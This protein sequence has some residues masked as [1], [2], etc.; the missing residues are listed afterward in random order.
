MTAT[1]VA[2]STRA[3]R[4]KCLNEHFRSLL[5]EPRPVGLNPEVVGL[6]A[7]APVPFGALAHDAAGS[8]MT[9]V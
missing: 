8:R 3:Y 2:S 6:A 1:T 9:R 7:R 5:S 4:S